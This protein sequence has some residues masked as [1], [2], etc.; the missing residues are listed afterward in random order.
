MN[1]A[2]YAIVAREILD[3]RGNPTIETTVVLNSGYRGTAAVPAGASRGKYEAVELRDNDEKRYNGMGVLK[4]ISNVMNIIGPKLRGRDA[5]KQQEIDTLMLKLDGTENK[6]KLGAN[7]ILSVSIATAIA[8]ANYQ[9]MPLYRYI[10]AVFS[11]FMQSPIPIQ[12]M[13]TPTFNLIN[14]G[15][16]GAGNLD[17][18]EFHVLPASNKPFSLAL[19]IGDEIYYAVKRMLEDRNAAHSVGDEGGFTPNL[20]TNTDALDI[21]IDAIRRTPYRLTVDVFLGLDIAASHFKTS[22]GYEIKDRSG[23][24]SSKEF[25]EF[26]KD[27]HEKY[28]LLLLEDPF[29]EDD[30]Q[31]WKEIT[32]LLKDEVFIIGDDLLATN[33]NRLQKAIEEQACSAILLKPNQIGSLTEFLQVVAIA[34]K[35]GITCITS[36]RSGET[37]DSYIADI[38]VGIQS[39]YVKFGAPARGERVAKYNRLLLIEQDM[40]RKQ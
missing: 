8:A 15:M 34:K 32:N 36:H 35:H 4:A 24:F 22:R 6:S 29:D 2:I 7:A 28:R 14:G 37:N 25:I 39:E 38:A 17:F 9:R 5:L 13:P 20:Y 18:Q 33:P 27:I 10:N 12:R 11:S 23:P 26:L 3:S 31:S 16:H 30:W 21:L 40:L 1:S 19:R